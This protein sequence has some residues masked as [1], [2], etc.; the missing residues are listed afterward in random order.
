MFASSW[1]SARIRGHCEC[2]RCQGR[3]T[4]LVIRTRIFKRPRWTQCER[5]SA[6]DQ[7]PLTVA[8]EKP[9]TKSYQKLREISDSNQNCQKLWLLLAIDLMTSLNYPVPVPRSE[10][11]KKFAF[12]ALNARWTF[13][14]ACL[15]VIVTGLQMSNI[16]QH[17]R[18]NRTFATHIQNLHVFEMV[19]DLKMITCHSASLWRHGRGNQIRCQNTKFEPGN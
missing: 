8:Y 1:K 13:L 5:P 18:E 6:H 7:K 3:N 15:N 4:S 9:L 19:Q 11:E 16:W 12:T 17:F 14:C 10:M 2:N